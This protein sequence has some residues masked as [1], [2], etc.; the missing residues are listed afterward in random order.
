MFIK[1]YFLTRTTMSVE[2]L[3]KRAFGWYA[4]WAV[5]HWG[6]LIVLPLLLTAL[7][8]LKALGIATQPKPDAKFLFTPT[9]APSWQ[10]VIIVLTF[11]VTVV[12]KFNRFRFASRK[13]LKIDR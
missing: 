8:G 2:N 12:H 13:V 9:D 10:E 11:S 5:R 3:M 7:L 4:P 1:V 6:L